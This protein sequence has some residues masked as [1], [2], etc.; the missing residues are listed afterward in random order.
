MPKESREREEVSNIK[1]M[2]L[3][4]RGPEEK[5]KTKHQSGQPGGANKNDCRKKK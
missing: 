2:L 1:G 4:G 5:A 3:I